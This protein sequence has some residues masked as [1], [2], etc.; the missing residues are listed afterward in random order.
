MEIKVCGMRELGNIQGLISEVKPDWMGL[1][2]YPKSP[3]YVTEDKAIDF[4]KVEVK[5]VGV[6]VNETEI[7]ILRKVNLFGLSAIQLHGS[8]SAEFAERL[9]QNTEAEIWK[10][11]SVKEEVDWESLEGYLPFVDKFLFDTATAAHGGSGKKFDWSVLETYPFDKSFLLSGGLD[12]E[13]AG[14]IL[15]LN[16]QIPQLS[17]V[18]L[19][20]KFEDA[21][22]LKNIEKL[23]KF[24]QKLLSQEAI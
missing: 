24:K 3:R 11:I 22:G 9:C 2:F 12:E 14:E 18:D 1:I 15:N 8:E 6:F 17:G 19:N 4:N 20:S 23:K 10:V 16:R 21:P 5:K 7:E 13:S